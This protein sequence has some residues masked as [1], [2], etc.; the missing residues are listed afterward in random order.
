[1]NGRR[2]GRQTAGREEKGR[3]G[4]VRVR[5][6]VRVPVVEECDI[7]CVNIRIERGVRDLITP[8]VLKNKLSGSGSLKL[9]RYIQIYR[10]ATASR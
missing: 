9:G 5:V 10:L 8:S 2:A 3:E 6:R 4:N 7:S 1:M